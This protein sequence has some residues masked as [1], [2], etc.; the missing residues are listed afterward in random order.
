VAP[1][2]L[3]RRKAFAEVVLNHTLVYQVEHVFLIHR[4]TGC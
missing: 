3:A 4:H 1:G 2:S